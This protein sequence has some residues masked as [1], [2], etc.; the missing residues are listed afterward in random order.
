VYNAVR[1]EYLSL[2]QAV[3]TNPLQPPPLVCWVGIDW[4]G[5]YA[6]SFAQYKVEYIR[7]CIPADAGM[8]APGSSS[9]E[10]SSTDAG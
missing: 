8:L 10:H 4:E 6:M 5:D 9:R 1:K 2:R 7:V 3:L